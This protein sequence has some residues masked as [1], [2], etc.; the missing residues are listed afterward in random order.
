MY[1]QLLQRVD[2][3]RAS[4]RTL[5]PAR[6][7]QA[8]LRRDREPSRR[9]PRREP[10]SATLLIES[11]YPS[12]RDDA[13]SSSGAGITS[14]A[15]A[16]R[17]RANGCGLP[18]SSA[19]TSERTSA[20]LADRGEPLA[21]HDELGAL[22]VPVLSN[23]TV[24]TQSELF[25]HLCASDEH[26][27]LECRL[28]HDPVH[29]RRRNRIGARASGE[30]DGKTGDDA[31]LQRSARIQKATVAAATS[32]TDGVRRRREWNRPTPARSRASP[33]GSPRDVRVERRRSPEPA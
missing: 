4:G 23:A 13:P 29:E 2:R 10:K 31:F 22:R 7:P 26:A 17:A 30:N 18:S 1:A 14:F 16:T 6:R 21:D 20:R 15:R 33:E 25:E 27:P 9:H 5:R 11:L 24:R 12:A 3:S 32:A 28:R 19:R 8:P